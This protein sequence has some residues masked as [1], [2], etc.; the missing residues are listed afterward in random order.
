M[1]LLPP[2]DPA[3]QMFPRSFIIHKRTSTRM[4]GTFDLIAVMPDTFTSWSEATCRAMELE[5]ADRGKT[6]NGRTIEYHVA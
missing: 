6:Y 3:T 2:I 5:A 1:A 4:D